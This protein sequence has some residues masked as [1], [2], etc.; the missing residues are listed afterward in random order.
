MRDE[1]EKKQQV[2]ND[3]H[4]RRNGNAGS[5]RAARAARKNHRHRLEHL[6]SSASEVVGDAR[7][8]QVQF[9]FKLRQA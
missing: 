5:R 9:P 3:V 6:P 1:H 8:E 2:E 7:Y 4:E